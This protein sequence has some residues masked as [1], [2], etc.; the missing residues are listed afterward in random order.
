MPAT[1]IQPVLNRASRNPVGR[2]SAALALTRLADG[3]IDG[4]SLVHLPDMRRLEHVHRQVARLP[5]P[6]CRPLGRA[7]R[8]VLLDAGPRPVAADGE[9]SLRPG[10]LGVAGH[11]DPA[12]QW[13]VA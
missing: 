1:R 2:S 3:D 5:E 13:E 8:R 7:V 6:L 9:G 4:P 11:D 12:D 10:S